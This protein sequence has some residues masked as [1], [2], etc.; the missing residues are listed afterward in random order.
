MEERSWPPRSEN[1]QEKNCLKLGKSHKFISR[2]EEFE[3]LCGSDISL[4]QCSKTFPA[5]KE[6]Q[7]LS[8]RALPLGR[9][10]AM[11]GGMLIISY[12]CILRSSC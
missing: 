9:E 7:K 8:F 2:K 11:N 1:V 5:A 4:P 6:M 3:T 10:R 12:R